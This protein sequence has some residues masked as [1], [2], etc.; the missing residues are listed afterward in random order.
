VLRKKAPYKTTLAVRLVDYC[1]S[2]RNE[3]EPEFFNSRNRYFA[4]QKLFSRIPGI[5]VAYWMSAKGLQNYIDGKLLSDFA[6]PKA[7][8]ATG[9]NDRF[10]R[11]WFEVGFHRIGF[12]YSSVDETK[13]CRYK[14]FPC[15]SGGVFRKWSFNNEMV[16]NWF[17][18]GCEIRTFKNANGRLAA[19]PQNTQ[20]YFQKGL[21]WNKL[22]SSRFAVK[23]KESGFIFDDTSRSIFISDESKLYYLLALLCS[24]VTFGYMKALNPT[25]SFT[26]GDIERIPFIYSADT[27]VLNRIDTIVEAN[28][29]MSRV[30]WD[31]FET[32]W[33]FKKHP[34]IYGCATIKEVYEQWAQECEDRFNKLKANEEELNRIFIDIYGLQDELTPEVD[35]KD[36]TVRKADLQ[37][38]MRSFVS[39]AVGCMFGRYS[40]DT[41]GLAYAGGE[42]DDSKYKTFIPD[43]DNCL[44][45]TEEHFFEDD[46]VTQFAN[47]VQAVFGEDTLEDNLRYVAENLGINGNGTAREKIRQYF[48]KDF[49]KDH[50]KI[51]QKRPIYW[52]FDT[53]KKNGFKALCYVHRWNVN[54]VGDVRIDY[55]HKLQRLYRNEIIRL[56]EKIDNGEEIAKSQ[57]RLEKITN[58]LKETEDY[59]AKIGMVVAART[60]IDLDDGVKVNYDKVQLGSD[61]KKYQILASI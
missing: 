20:Y 8:L 5:P 41:E 13:D 12:G 3:K 11:I 23:L 55:M 18:D 53:G 6:K 46:I 51:Y 39:Y 49:F 30:D 57:K 45:I 14:W 4:D 26:N 40:L 60:E 59:D 42:W 38:D 44:P 33:D 32:S 54:T 15:N 58:Q 25:M 34:F 16:V 61:G 2:R 48:L 7:G 21:T 50:C 37:R 43:K 27:E 28:I 19:R 31:S 9:D 35:D 56:Q 1:L 17:N 22:S 52:M 36:I 47:F 29:K 24:C 10:E